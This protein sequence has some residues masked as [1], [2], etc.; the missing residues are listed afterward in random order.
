MHLIKMAV[1]AEHIDHLREWQEQR[2]EEAREKGLPPV[3][4]HITRNTPKRAEAV[5]AAGC[6]YWVI[7][8]YIRV[9]QRII[10]LDPAGGEGLP[11]CA[12]A[13]DA[14]L[15]PTVPR[16]QRPFQ[17]WRYLDPRDAPPDL[18]AVIGGTGDALPEA[19]A[20]ELRD[21]GLL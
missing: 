17:G 1:G 10:G 21:L 3:A 12:I 14:V 5:L 15:V 9:R 19:L 4:R 2:R 16:R 6:M 13:L 20:A 18:D 7:G 8:G 11:R